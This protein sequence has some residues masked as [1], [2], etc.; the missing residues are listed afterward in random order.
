MVYRGVTA[1]SA[2]KITNMNVTAA[3]TTMLPTTIYPNCIDKPVS[4]IHEL[5]FQKDLGRAAQ[6]SG[7]GR[8][9]V[10][11]SSSTTIAPS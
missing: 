4:I 11:S 3:M 6:Q 8:A 10:A 7:L 9:A 5:D 2:P 1:C